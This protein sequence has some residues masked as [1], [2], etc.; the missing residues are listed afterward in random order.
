MEEGIFKLYCTN[1]YKVKANSLVCSIAN[2]IIDGIDNIF[3]VIEPK[4]LSSL[5]M[6]NSAL[7]VGPWTNKGR[8]FLEMKGLI[9]GEKRNE[10]F[11]FF[12]G[13]IFNYPSSQL[14]VEFVKDHS[15]IT[16]DIIRIK[17]GYQRKSPYFGYAP[18]S[19]EFIEFA[20]NGEICVNKQISKPE[21]Y[22]TFVIKET[23]KIGQILSRKF[24]GVNFL[25]AIDLEDYIDG[26][27]HKI[28]NRGKYHWGEVKG[29]INS[30]SL[31]DS[32]E[33]S[34]NLKNHIAKLYYQKNLHY[35]E[36]Q[37]ISHASMDPG[38]DDCYESTDKYIWAAFSFD[39]AYLLSFIA[40]METVSSFTYASK[41]FDSIICIRF[42][43]IMSKSKFEELTGIHLLEYVE[44]SSG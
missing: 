4:S 7:H 42:K 18:F 41:Y 17:G 30:D 25:D 44:T 1:L 2:K 39:E 37:V 9:E 36:Y 6:D 24:V 16:C 33:F 23:P 38:P 40:K 20:A 28:M 22:D 43:D 12:R 26:V 19:I 34:I 3:A 10:I 32:L 5:Y 31:I 14:K 8:E 11:S 29:S 13:M 15:T 27:S 21:E 35:R